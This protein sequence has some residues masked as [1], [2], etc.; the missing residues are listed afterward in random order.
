MILSGDRSPFL[1]ALVLSEKIDSAFACCSFEP[2]E[3]GQPPSKRQQK[4]IEK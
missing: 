2:G 1:L 4:S 3:R